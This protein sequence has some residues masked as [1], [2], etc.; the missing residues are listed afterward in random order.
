MSQ[1]NE[2]SEQKRL[3][4]EQR[5]AQAKERMTGL[6][7][8]LDSSQA[9]GRKLQEKLQQLVE[10]TRQEKALVAR[11]SEERQGLAAE[12][13]AAHQRHEEDARALA[14][15]REENDTQS[16]AL[17]QSWED[18]SQLSAQLDE[19]KKVRQELEKQLSALQSG[20]KNTQSERD[21]IR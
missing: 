17:E 3:A 11:G 18:A 1:L 12:L 5:W 8:E 9:R 16:L 21:E 13:E 4:F 7:R 15:L 20:L 14:D 10:V 19:Q 2:S 6:Q